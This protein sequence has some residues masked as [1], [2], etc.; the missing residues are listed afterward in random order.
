MRL[1]KE[2]KSSIHFWEQWPIWTPVV[3]L[4]PSSLMI[5]ENSLSWLAQ[6]LWYIRP[7]WVCRCLENIFALMALSYMELLLSC[8]ICLAIHP[9]VQVERG[10]PLGARS[11]PIFG[12]AINQEEVAA[13][14]SPA[15]VASPF[16]L[17]SQRPS[18]CCEV[19][20][21]RGVSAQE[22]SWSFGESDVL[23]VAFPVPSSVS[24]DAD[25]IRLHFIDG[26]CGCVGWNTMEL[27]LGLCR[28]KGDIEYN[29]KE[30]I[31]YHK[32]ELSPMALQHVDKYIASCCSEAF[33]FQFLSARSERFLPDWA[34]P[35]KVETH[36]DVWPPQ[37]RVG[38]GAVV[39]SCVYVCVCFTL[40]EHGRI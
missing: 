3:R 21:G 27:R 12:A 20:V 35:G 28:K 14:L 39:F 8:A 5:A 38:W 6:D 13:K 17:G 26:R 25:C 10:G 19:A 9:Q 15:T 36:L 32:C 34:P 37:G 30:V 40:V 11:L 4:L 1:E 33:D 18:C 22:M 23:S 16:A 29:M 31:N 2:V 7:I 24:K